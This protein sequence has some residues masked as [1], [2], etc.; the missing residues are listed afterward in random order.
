MPY[1]LVNLE[2]KSKLHK[3]FYLFT[4]SLRYRTFPD[5]TKLS[6]MSNFSQYSP[7]NTTMYILFSLRSCLLVGQFINMEMGSVCLCLTPST[8]PY[9]SELRQLAS[10]IGGHCIFIAVWRFTERL[11]HHLGFCYMCTLWDDYSC[12]LLF[13]HETSISLGYIPKGRLLVCRT[14]VCFILIYVLPER[15]C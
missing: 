3:C 10:H 13:R 2:K 9:F 14:D 11:H 12:G 4:S 7:P 5:I 6:F 8:Q 1:K 15:R